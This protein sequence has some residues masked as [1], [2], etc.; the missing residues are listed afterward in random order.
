MQML[1][2][3]LVKLKQTMWSLRP[4]FDKFGLTS[5]S[6]A[7]VI[8]RKERLM[9]VQINLTISTRPAAD[10]HAGR[11]KNIVEIFAAQ[12]MKYFGAQKRRKHW[13]NRKANSDGWCMHELTTLCIIIEEFRN[14][15]NEL[16]K[17]NGLPKRI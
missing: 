12:P 7:T 17:I 3:G 4:F 1:D 14:F 13:S 9:K 6:N 5:N 15:H 8:F 16:P 10:I 2:Y 11:V